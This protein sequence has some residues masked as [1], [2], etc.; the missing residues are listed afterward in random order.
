[1][2][3]HKS[4]YEAIET[5]IE[6]RQILNELI[7]YSRRN[8]NQEME[9]PTVEHYQESNP[10]NDQSAVQ[11]SGNYLFKSDFISFESCHD[12]NLFI[13]LEKVIDLVLNILCLILCL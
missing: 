8:K 6:T 1:M 7:V 9:L 5:S 2:P 10:M 4:P 11:N 13:R 12:L 3:S